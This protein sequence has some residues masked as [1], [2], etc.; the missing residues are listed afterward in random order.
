[1]AA[2]RPVSG[3]ASVAVDS[4][5]AKE[6]CGAPG[7]EYRAP[8]LRRRSCLNLRTPED[9]RSSGCDPVASTTSGG[10]CHSERLGRIIV[11]CNVE[12]FTRVV[13]SVLH[14]T[15]SK[16]PQLASTEARHGGQCSTNVQ[17]NSVIN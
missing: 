12:V 10:S 1:M 15:Q 16:M 14:R 13:A 8:W 11:G 4:P 6:V 7:H 3:S 5:D 9:E 2:G 17:S